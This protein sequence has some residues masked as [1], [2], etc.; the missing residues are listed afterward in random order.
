MRQHGEDDGRGGSILA[1][2]VVS[3]DTTNSRVGRRALG[4]PRVECDEEA[5]DCILPRGQL[6]RDLRR[7]GRELG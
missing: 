3:L 2:K 5:E 6:R 1:V 4:N 7:K